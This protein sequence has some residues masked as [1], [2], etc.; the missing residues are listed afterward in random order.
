MSCPVP[1]DVNPLKAAPAITQAV[2][3]NG[4]KG[5]IDIN[6]FGDFNFLSE[7]LLDALGS[8]DIPVTH[9][10]RG[11]FLPFLLFSPSHLK[12]LTVPLF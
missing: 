7:R 3:A 8:S 11:S 2:R 5:P 4:I 9:F 6:A 10:P 1:N 12:L